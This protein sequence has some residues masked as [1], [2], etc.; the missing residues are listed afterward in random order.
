MRMIALVA[1]A[2]AGMSLTSTFA[3]AGTGAEPIDGAVQI[4]AIPRQRNA[5]PRCA[6]LGDFANRIHSPGWPTGLRR[7]LDPP[8]LAKAL[9]ARLLAR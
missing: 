9:S 6:A 1:I 8:R 7:E 4:A 5:W 2:P 3:D